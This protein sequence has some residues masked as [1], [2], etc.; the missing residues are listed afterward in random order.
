MKHAGFDG[1]LPTSSRWISQ[2]SPYPMI[3]GAL[4]V[5]AALGPGGCRRDGVIRPVSPTERLAATSAPA[6]LPTTAPSDDLYKG[7]HSALSPERRADLARKIAALKLG[8]SIES[9][10]KALGSPDDIT[11]GDVKYSTPRKHHSK[12]VTYMVARYRDHLMTEGKD[13][14]VVLWFDSDSRLEWVWSNFAPVANRETADARDM[15]QPSTKLKW[16]LGPQP[17]VKWRP[18]T[19]E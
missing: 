17:L 14:M 5:A 9:V 12:E 1:W 3:L 18:T 19:R 16:P 6:T 8:D 2:L 4:V 15:S 11:N 10:V 13:K 7:Y